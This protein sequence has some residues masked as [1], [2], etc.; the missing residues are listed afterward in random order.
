MFQDEAPLLRAHAHPANADTWPA[1]VNLVVVES[2]GSR[3]DRPDYLGGGGQARRHR[4]ACNRGHGLLR[5]CVEFEV[6]LAAR[7]ATSPSI[8]AGDRSSRKHC[9]DHKFEM[10]GSA[11]DV[12][13]NRCKL[14]LLSQ[15]WDD[16]GVRRVPAADERPLHWVGSSKRDFLSFPCTSS[17]RSRRSRRPA[18]ERPSGMSIASPNA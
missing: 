11:P 6:A 9:S 10:T 17:M 1:A 18:S 5:G 4:A 3:P 12:T 13:V 15:N 7:M 8:I 2:D 16:L 14:A